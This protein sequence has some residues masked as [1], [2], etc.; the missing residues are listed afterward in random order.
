[1]SNYN[2]NQSTRVFSVTPSPSGQNTSKEIWE[3]FL[4]PEID[5]I[6]IVNERTNRLIGTIGGTVSYKFDK[7]PKSYVAQSP[8]DSDI[9]GDV[10]DGGFPQPINPFPY[11]RLENGN[12]ATFDYNYAHTKDG[13]FIFDAYELGSTDPIDGWWI[14]YKV[15]DDDPTLLDKVAELKM[16]SSYYNDGSV[17]SYNK[18]EENNTAYFVY[19]QFPSSDLTLIFSTITKIT[20]SQSGT[21]YSLSATETTFNYGGANVISLYNDFAPTPVL[22]GAATWVY[23]SPYFSLQ[24]DYF[25]LMNGVDEGW[26]WYGDA[27]TATSLFTYQMGFN[28]LTGETAFVEPISSLALTTN[29]NP[30]GVVNSSYFNNNTWESHPSGVLYFVDNNQPLDN[31]NNTNSVTALF[32]PRWINNTLVTFLN[33]RNAD[34]FNFINGNGGI[35][36]PI[37]PSGSAFGFDSEN[38]YQTYRQIAIGGYVQVFNRFKLDSLVKEQEIQILP[39]QRDFASFTFWENNDTFIYSN[40]KII[41]SV[42]YTRFSYMYWQSSSPK[43]IQLQSNNYFPFTIIGNKFYSNYGGLTRNSLQ[44]GIEYD[45]YNV[46]Q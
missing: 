6:D 45:V 13:I 18:V 44:L 36:N 24:N 12:I 17:Y 31:G 10:V 14:A 4:T 46:I 11:I 2:P 37:T 1:M 3:G 33:S 15:N 8:A 32:S 43:A 39:I 26:V 30:A 38:F 29:F 9:L 5:A 40:I 27:T 19:Y 28:L 20:V 42:S 16:T 41:D 23:R 34:G 7:L 21:T 22:P 35:F 25:G